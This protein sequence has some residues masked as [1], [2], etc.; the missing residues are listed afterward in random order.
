MSDHEHRCGEGKAGHLTC[1]EIS[2]FLLGYLERDLDE[3]VLAEFDTH[4]QRCPPCGHYLES[5]R[6]TVELVRRC[7]KVE[8]DA[9]AKAKWQAPPEDLIQAILK[10]KKSTAD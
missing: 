7:G 8:C 1:R 3:Q 10:A 4:L 6:E 2:E 9:E 5:Y